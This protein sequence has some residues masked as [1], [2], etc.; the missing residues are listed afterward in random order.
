MIFVIKF[1]EHMSRSIDLINLFVFV[2][3]EIQFMS[4]V[5]ID[6]IKFVIITIMRSVIIMRVSIIMKYMIKKLEYKIIYV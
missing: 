1:K 2:N 5:L 4:I 3:K 6:M